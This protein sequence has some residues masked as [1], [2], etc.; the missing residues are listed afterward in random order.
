MP[1]KVLASWSETTT[2]TI[3]SHGGEFGTDISPAVT[4]DKIYNYCHDNILTQERAIRD[5]KDYNSADFEVSKSKVIAYCAFYDDQ[6]YGFCGN[7]I[8]IDC[9][10]TC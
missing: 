7:T 2:K 1:N 4:L 10:N 6:C 9:F 3:G 5:G 8:N